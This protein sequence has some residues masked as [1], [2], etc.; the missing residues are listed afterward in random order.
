[1]K[2]IILKIE[3]KLNLKFN[4]KTLKKVIVFM[5]QLIILG[6]SDRYVDYIIY[7]CS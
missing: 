2:N 6:V 7:L 4:P 1:M 3:L 5:V